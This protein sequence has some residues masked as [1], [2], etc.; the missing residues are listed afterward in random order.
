MDLDIHPLFVHFPIAFLSI[1]AI[2]ELLR[3]K[4]LTM[5]PE[6][7]YI[8]AVLLFVGVGGALLALATGALTASGF[9]T[10]PPQLIVH[11]SLGLMTTVTFSLLAVGYIIAWLERG[12]CANWLNNNS[13]GRFLLGLKYWLNETPLTLFLAVIGLALVFITG[14]LGGSMV[15]G[16]E[17]D[18]FIKF[19]YTL[20]VR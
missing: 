13:F 4:K 8:K 15:Y 5:R 20:L 1:Y 10:R 12:G 18:P 6:L 14:A 2:A 3:F 11:A 16:P 9:T 7:F 19:I 17:G